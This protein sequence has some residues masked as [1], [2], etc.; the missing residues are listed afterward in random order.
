MKPSNGATWA[1]CI[2]YN[3]TVNFG[4]FGHMKDDD[5]SIKESIGDSEN[6]C[7]CNDDSYFNVEKNDTTMVS[8]F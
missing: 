2:S 4:S 6:I 5:G 3:K 8:V 1:V 7:P